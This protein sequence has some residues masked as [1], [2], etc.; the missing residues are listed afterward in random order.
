LGKDLEI[1]REWSMW[2][3]G[4]RTIQ[5]ECRGLTM[6]ESLACQEISKGETKRKVGQCNILERWWW[7]RSFWKALEATGKMW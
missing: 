7:S 3:S 1:L 6:G 2:N 5:H 4:E